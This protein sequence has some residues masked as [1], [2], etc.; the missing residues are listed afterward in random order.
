MD[1]DPNGE[2][3]VHPAWRKT[4]IHYTSVTKTD[5]ETEDAERWR[6]ESLIHS[7]RFTKLREIT[8]NSGT[9]APESDYYEPD[10]EKNFFGDNYERLKAIKEK[11]DPDYMFQVW[12]GV[13]GLRPETRRSVL[14]TIT[15]PTSPW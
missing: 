2:T 15:G 5:L 14:D 10:W 1:A 9:Y 3:A 8:P 7:Q 13:G 6:T 4:V 11:Y 12:N